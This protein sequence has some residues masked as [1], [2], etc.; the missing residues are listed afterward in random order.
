MALKRSRSYCSFHRNPPLIDP[1][2]KELAK[3]LSLVGGPH[4]GSTS[5][6]PICKPIPGPDLVPALIPIPVPAPIPAPVPINKL[7]KKFLKAYLESNQG[8]RQSLAEREQIFKAKI[9]EVYYGKL[10]MNCYHFC[11]QCKDYFKTSRATRANRT[12]FVASFLH[13]NI[14]VHRAEFKYCNRGEELTPIA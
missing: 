11:Q 6:V 8:S 14:S 10:Y 2:K 12:L 13:K 9:S 4:S 5:S 3:D 7:F 1:V